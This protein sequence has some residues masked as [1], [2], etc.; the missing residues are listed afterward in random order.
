MRIC[1][2]APSASYLASAGV[3]IRYRRI[4]S[5]LS[6]LGHELSVLPIT[7]F[8]RPEDFKHDVYIISK[9]YDARALVAARLIAARGGTLGVDLFDDYYSQ[10]SDSRFI[11]RREW[12]RALLASADFVLCSTPAMQATAQL[13]APNHPAHLLNDPYGQ[14][15]R[16]AVAAALARKIERL[17]RT[18]TLR[19]GWFGVGDNPYF[20][21]GLA[22]LAAFGGELARLRTSRFDVRLEILTN[23]RAVTADA[24]AALRRLPLP[25]ELDEWSEQG[26]ATLLERCTACFL[27]VNAQSFSVVKSL[28]RA[29]TALTGG[30]QVLSAGYPLYES[31]GEFIYRDAGQLLADLVDCRPRL[32]EETLEAFAHLMDSLASPRAEAHKLSAF[33][34]KLS[35]GRTTQMPHLAV[36]HGPY[37]TRDV[38]LFVQRMGGLS[39]ASPFAKQQLP[40]DVRFTLRPNGQGI[41]LL[42]ASDKR[43][44]LAP[45]FAAHLVPGRKILDTSYHQLDLAQLGGEATWDTILGR[46]RNPAAISA[47]L[48]DGMAFVERALSLLFPGITCVRSLARRPAAE[49]GAA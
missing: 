28:N 8:K 9:C 4:E 39:V 2:L 29:V 1:V 32:R 41:D 26:E 20:S 14:L 18:R 19:L 22:D 5:P 38:H 42:I 48:G 36:V 27:P 23:R 34:Q 6:E 35:H 47:V 40:Y 7:E 33:L 37:S 13:V 30:T 45:K 24:L 49:K 43:R 17:H 12:L 31:L 16:R 10:V 25:F 15:D 11:W 21:V 3:R 44:S 46:L